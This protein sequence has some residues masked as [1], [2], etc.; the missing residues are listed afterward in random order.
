MLLEGLLGVLEIALYEFYRNPEKLV[1][2]VMALVISRLSTNT[3]VDDASDVHIAR[4]ISLRNPR[5][6]ISTISRSA[7]SASTNFL[8]NS[9]KQ[10]NTAIQLQIKNT[11]LLLLHYWYLFKTCYESLFKLLSLPQIYCC[12]QAVWTLS[13]AKEDMKAVPW[14]QFCILC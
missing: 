6:S 8:R 10:L 2:F 4:R 7:G 11:I 1:V 14:R 5:L 13:S 9:A 12:S 3:S